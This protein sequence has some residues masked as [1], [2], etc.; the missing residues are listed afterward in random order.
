MFKL[1]KI[2]GFMFKI[3]CFSWFCSKFLKFKVFQVFFSINL[4][5]QGFSMFPGKEATLKII[6]GRVATHSGNSGNLREFSNC[7]KSQGNSGNLRETQ[8]ILAFFF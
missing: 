2:P 4:Q 8:G 7:R 3:Q 5:T 1:Y 6:S